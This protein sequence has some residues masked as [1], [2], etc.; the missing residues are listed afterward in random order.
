[1]PKTSRLSMS[2]VQVIRNYRVVLIVLR[3]TWINIRLSDELWQMLHSNSIKDI[4]SKMR[5]AQLNDS[6]CKDILLNFLKPPFAPLGT[7]PINC[8]K[9]ASCVIRMQSLISAALA[10]T[11]SGASG[12]K[13]SARKMQVWPRSV[14]TL[15]TEA[16]IQ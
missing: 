4:A 1:M 13:T 2:S 6:H 11:M 5:L 3:P 16:G 9:S 15:A 12:G 8:L 10:T 7:F 14:R